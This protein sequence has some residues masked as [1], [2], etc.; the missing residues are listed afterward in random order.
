MGTFQRKAVTFEVIEVDNS[1]LPFFALYDVHK[2]HKLL[3]HSKNNF[4]RKTEYAEDRTKWSKVYWYGKIGKSK[5]WE[6]L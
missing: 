4:M 5:N 1:N 2:S 6:N 3:R